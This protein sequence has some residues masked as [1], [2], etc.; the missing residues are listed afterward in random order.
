MSLLVAIAALAGAALADPAQEA[1]AQAL[2]REIRCVVCQNEPI[3]QSTAEIAADMRG[4]VRER[5]EAGDSDAEIRS[6]FRQR[7]GDFVLLRPPMDNRTWMLWAAPALL[8]A[9]GLLAVARTWRRDA[10]PTGKA[11]PE[12]DER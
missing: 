3:A 4:V 7:Y 6:F 11:L 5:I 1:R 10:A 2:E 9:L 8:L 12:E